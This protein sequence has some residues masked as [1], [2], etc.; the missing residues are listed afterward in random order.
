VSKP[1][2]NGPQRGLACAFAPY[3][4][5]ALKAVVDLVSAFPTGS[6]NKITEVMLPLLEPYFAVFAIHLGG[7]ALLFHDPVMLDRWMT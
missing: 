3:P 1:Q 4:Y 7:S 6:L 2:I 5:S